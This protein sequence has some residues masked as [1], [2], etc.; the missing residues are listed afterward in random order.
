MP[1]TDQHTADRVHGTLAAIEDGINSL[2]KAARVLYAAHAVLA[3]E[4][5]A[6]VDNGSGVGIISRSWHVPY[7]AVAIDARKTTQDV[8]VTPDG[9]STGPPAAGTAV[10]LIPLGHA[11]V[12]NFAGRQLTLYGK[13]GEIVTIQLFAAA[14]PPAWG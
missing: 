8:T 7:G 4:T 13:P 14:Q 10:G 9:A 11:A 12:L 1:R 2:T 6:F 5:R 3:V